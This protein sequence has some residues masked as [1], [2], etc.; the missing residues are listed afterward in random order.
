VAHHRYR[1]GDQR[2]FGDRV[3]DAITHRRGTGVQRAARPGTL[4]RP[5]QRGQHGAKGHARVEQQAPVHIREDD[6]AAEIPVKPLRQRIEVFPARGIV[7]QGR[8]RE[9]LQRLD[10]PIEAVVELR[11]DTLGEVGGRE[12]PFR[13]FAPNTFN[14]QIAGH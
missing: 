5:C 13:L 4:L 2:L 9:H 7:H 6:V 3:E 1:D 14:G 8:A 12:I 11:G 10:A